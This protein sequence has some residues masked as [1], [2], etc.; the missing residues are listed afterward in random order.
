MRILATNDDGV[1]APGLWALVR[2]L[3]PLGEVIVSAPDRDR[4]GIGSA[5]TLRGPIR[6][7][8]LLSPVDG[9]NAHAIDGTPGD[10][11]LIG[12]NELAGG[13]V[14]LVVSGINP[15]NNGGEEIR[16]SG[17]VGAALHAHLNGIPALAV[18]THTAEDADADL[19]QTVLRAMAA[20][21][22]SIGAG[23]PLFLNLNFPVIDPASCAR[24]Q[25][26]AI[27]AP[28]AGVLLT[29]PFPGPVFDNIAY[30]RR[31][32][33]L[34]FWNARHL[35]LKRAD[36]L[37]ADSDLFALVN[38]YVSVTSLDDKLSRASPSAIV[39]TVV[40]MAAEAIST[41]G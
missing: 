28:T 35:A 17:T 12:I 24:H 14:D 13:P 21:M 4:S 37:P 22:V 10:A 15:G 5:L 29:N 34:S 19:V 40:R 39:D 33:R 27:P 20:G 18:S 26:E 9:V 3:K 41:P 23:T 6:A 36:V 31:D 25:H 11:V 1:H 38:G 8:K 7:A 2:A 16:L 32:G 30:G